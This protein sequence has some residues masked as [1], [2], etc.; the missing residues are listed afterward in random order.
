M[1]LAHSNK[2]CC[3]KVFE[4]PVYGVF[5]VSLLAILA[6]FHMIELQILNYNL[7]RFTHTKF[8]LFLLVLLLKKQLV[9]NIITVIQGDT[10]SI[11]PAPQLSY[12][13]HSFR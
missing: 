13:V 10:L 7:I 11:N 3:L 1:S 4:Q 8:S 6:L 12:A 2:R 5:S 9:K